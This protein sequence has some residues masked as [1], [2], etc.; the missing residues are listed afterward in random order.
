MI[1]GGDF[2]Q[3]LPV[4]PKGTIAQTI[5]ARVVKSTLW[6]NVKV[7]RLRQNMR[8][9]HDPA[10][11][12]FLLRVGNGGEPTLPEDMIRLPQSMAIPWEGEESIKH[13]INATFPNLS[14]HASD[15]KYMVDR[16]LITPLNEDVDKLNEMVIHDFPGEETIYYSFDLV[17]DDTRNLYQQEFLNSISPGGL[18]PHKLV[19]KKGAPIMLLRNIDP[20][21]GLC[22]VTRLL[23]RR[24]DRN[25]IDAEILT[26]HYSGSR[27][28]L[29]RIP[30]KTA[31]GVHLPFE[32]TRK[33]FPIK[34]SFALTIIKSQ[35]QT[36][37]NVGVYLPDHVFSHG[38][39]YVALSRGVSANTTKVLI[40]RGT[41]SRQEGIYTPNIVFKDIFSSLNYN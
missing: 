7:L 8:A 38:Q 16:A 9:Q 37:P 34:L 5:D 36:I 19:L 40:R 21:I 32:M 28:F 35:G 39:L 17:V 1:M 2:R 18:P 13:L 30:L 29:P 22:N 11:S 12:D 20:K 4:V 6:T 31:E 41:V 3:V 33:Q 24:F 25:V 15:G 26:G 23:C 10:F 14:A 27:V